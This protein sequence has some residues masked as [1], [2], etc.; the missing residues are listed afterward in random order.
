MKM[1]KKNIPPKTTIHV[2]ETLKGACILQYINVVLLSPG[3]ATAAVVVLTGL[4]VVLCMAGLA[5]LGCTKI[6]FQISVSLL[7]SPIKKKTMIIFVLT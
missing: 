1:Y 2:H 7:N 5:L 3:V 6:Q 4:G